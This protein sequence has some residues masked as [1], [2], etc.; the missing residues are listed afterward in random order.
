MHKDDKPINIP[1]I[2]KFFK[3]KSEYI[4]TAKSMD[5]AKRKL[6]RFSLYKRERYHIKGGYKDKTN[7]ERIAVFLSKTFMAI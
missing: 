4:L 2:I 6:K 5:K 3:E 7:E 1:K